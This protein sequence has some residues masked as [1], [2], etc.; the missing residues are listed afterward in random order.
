MLREIFFTCG[1]RYD[2]GVLWTMIGHAAIITMNPG[3]RFG[4]LDHF[5]R[6]YPFHVCLQAYG[7]YRC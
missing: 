7:M 3:A 4:W 5:L 1:D 6:G 2:Y